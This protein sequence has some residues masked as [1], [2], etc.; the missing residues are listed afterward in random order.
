MSVRVVHGAN[1]GFF[2]VE[3]MTIQQVIRQLRDVMNIPSDACA[4]VNGI[5][6]GH[7]HI[8]AVGDNVEF[9]RCDGQKGGVHEFW[10]ENEITS[11]FGEGAVEEM[12]NVGIKPRCQLVYT[13]DQISNWQATRIGSKV[14]KHGLVVDPETFT[15]S[16]QGQE[17]FI[18]ESLLFRLLARLAKRPGHFISFNILKAEVWRD[19]EAEDSTVARTLRRLRQKLR[20]FGITGIAVE[21]QGHHARLQLN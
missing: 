6:V 18:E 1:E 7:D 13:A 3:G 10:A 17:G 21:V 2:P 4:S 19:G 15:V 5:E 14:P 8:V 9:I 11:L 20:S 16:Y 12:T